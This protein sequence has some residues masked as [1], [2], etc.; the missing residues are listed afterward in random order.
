MMSDLG[1]IFERFFKCHK[2]KK[3]HED[4]GGAPDSRKNVKWVGK[5]LKYA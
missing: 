2:K 4:G 3:V 1:S 5:L